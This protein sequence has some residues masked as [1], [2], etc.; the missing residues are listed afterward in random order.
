MYFHGPFS[1]AEVFSRGYLVKYTA[2]VDQHCTEYVGCFD[3]ALTPKGLIS[4]R[5]HQS[6]R[7]VTQTQTALSATGQDLGLTI[8][9]AIF[10]SVQS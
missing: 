7:G 10:L 3:A 9:V 6:L 5:I 1:M 8:G 2:K 4:F